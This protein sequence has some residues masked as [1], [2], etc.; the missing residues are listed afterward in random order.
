M[1]WTVVAADAR[2]PRARRTGDGAPFVGEAGVVV[3]TVSR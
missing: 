3:D 1:W 2:A